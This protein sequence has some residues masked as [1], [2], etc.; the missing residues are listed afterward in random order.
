MHTVHLNGADA[1][2]IADLMGGVLIMTNVTDGTALISGGDPSKTPATD[3]PDHRIHGK[4]IFI[5]GNGIYGHYLVDGDQVYKFTEI[6][7][8][9]VAQKFHTV[10]DL[11]LNT[12]AKL[13]NDLR[14]EGKI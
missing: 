13:I 7:G 3:R 5:E 8:D 10:G 2:K 14:G 6:D 4:T 12:E 9:E 11:P 1:Q